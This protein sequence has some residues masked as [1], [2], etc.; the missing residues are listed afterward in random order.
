MQFR[1]LYRREFITLLGGAAAAW[2]LAAR[3]Q[4]GERMRRIGILMS[5]AERDAQARADQA[6]FVHELNELGWTEGRNVHIDTR[7]GTADAGRMLTDA[8]N[9]VALAPDLILA[10]GGVTM[11]ALLQ[12]TRTVPIVF[13]Q[14]LDPVGA[15]YVESLARPGGNVT[16]FTNFEYGMS[17]KWLE[18]VKQIVPDITRAAVLRDPGATS[19]T[20][21]FAAI[22]AVA[23]FLKVDLT[24]L[25]L[26]DVG[27]IERNIAEFARG[28][29]GGLIVVPGA[30]AVVHRELIITLAARHRLPA[31]YPYRYFTTGGGLMSYGPNPTDQFRQA[32]GYAARILKSE[33]PGD[34]PV[35]APTRYELVI[36]LRTAKALGLEVPPTLLARAD[37]VIE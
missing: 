3:A 10:S 16:G 8:R 29:N 7:W 5:G 13:L 30:L 21:Q 34:L 25:G 27:E 19:G 14:V 12:A 26:S 23:P 31:I 11:Q 32:A 33:K 22:Q 28:M 24:P 1:Q 2:P 36:N 17:G 18:L 15:G 9:L 35:Q 20:A 6:A 37:E 4:Q